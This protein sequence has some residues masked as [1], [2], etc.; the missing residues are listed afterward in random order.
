M[1]AKDQLRSRV[2]ALS[3]YECQHLSRL[4]DAVTAGERFWEGD[5]AV[6]YNEYVKMRSFNVSRNPS[7]FI[8]AAPAHEQG[9]FA[10]IS[11]VKTYPTS[12]RM[13]LPPPSEI[14]ASLSETI[15]QRRSSRVY[16]DRPISRVQ[17][18]TLLQHAAGI[19]GSVG[20]YDFNRLPLRAFPSA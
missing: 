11:L 18:A 19:T 9:I 14:G 4:V 10:P 17:L 6:F 3:E 5:V 12:T 20:A 2:E 15:V 16:A 8:S 1:S 13:E 7:S